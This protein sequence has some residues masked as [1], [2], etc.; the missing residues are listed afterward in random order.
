VTAGKTIYDAFISYSH[1]LDG[2]LAPTLRREVER[3]TKPLFRPRALRVFRD[4]ANLSAGPGLWSAIEEALAGSDWL[5]LMASPEAAQS[6]WVDREV[7]WWL[8][9]RSPRRLLIVLTSGEFAWDEQGGA[10]DAAASTAIPPSLHGAFDEE[11]RWVD[12]RWLRQVEQ[13]DRA[14]PRLQESVADIAAAVRDVPKDTLIGEHIR[15]HRRTL[16]LA[17]SAVTALAT[18][19]VVAV[20]AGAIAAVQ[21]NKAVNQARIATARQLAANALASTDT[22]VDLAQLLAVEAY[23]MDRGPQTRS[24]LFQAVAASPN[25][26]RTLPIGAAV[27]SLAGSADGRFAVAGTTDGKLVRWNVTDNTTSEIHL[28]GAAIADAAISEDGGKVVLTDGSKAWLW[29]AKAGRSPAQLGAANAKSVAISPSGRVVATMSFQETGGYYEQTE[30]VLSLVDGQSGKEL[31]HLATHAW[32]KI[33]LPDDLSVL[34]AN[35]PEWQVRSTATLAVITGSAGEISPPAGFF[36]PGFS[37]DGRFFGYVANSEAFVVNDQAVYLG[38]RDLSAGTGY[39]GGKIPISAPEHFVINDRG[40]Y[41]AS[42]GGGLLYAA[43]LHQDPG[44]SR[45]EEPVRLSGQGRTDAL[46]FLGHGTRLVSAAGGVLSLWDVAQPTRLSRRPVADLPAVPTAGET[47]NLAVTPDGTRVAVTNGNNLDHNTPGIL[48]PAIHEFSGPGLAT[49]A[50]ATEYAERVPL[51]TPDARR[52]LLI[53]N[54]G[55]ADILQDGR[56]VGQWPAQGSALVVA[57][58]VSPDGSRVLLIDELGAVQVRDAVNGRVRASTPSLLTKDTSSGSDPRPLAVDATTGTA[59]VVLPDGGQV[60]VID[61]ELGQSHRL[62]GDSAETV[63]FGND[64]LFVQHQDGTLDVWDTS[65]TTKRRTLTGDAGYAP[66]LAAIPHT[67][68]LARLRGDGTMLISDLETGDVLGSVRLPPMTRSS[69][70]DPW[71]VTTLT[72]TQDTSELI[73]ATSGGQLVHWQLTEDAW[74]RA[75]CGTAARDLTPAEW[76]RF[77]ATDPPANLSCL[78]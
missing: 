26:V 77:V 11:P 32:D 31:R 37:A 14:N 25:L 41:A 65:G 48:G 29:D 6:P 38:E 7:S 2:K 1:A 52:L 13:I 34:V 75:A 56:I 21:R 53:T 22:Q 67:T 24:A 50:L 49:S 43:H 74:I 73:T 36:M 76:H 58:Q 59:A 8:A 35:G 61:V 27:K 3:F 51:W 5:I 64:N 78:R 54:G 70:P 71:S 72:A 68:L 23:R 9:N 42:A 66:V 40:T 33:A 28:G 45:P 44:R 18:L 15:Q 46:A 10:V 60:V 30:A 4:D 12:L 19:L 39:I 20:V 57:G 63:V 62:P 47:P 17:W 55:A 69:A 16:R